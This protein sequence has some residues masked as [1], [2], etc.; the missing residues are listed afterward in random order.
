MKDSK[1]DNRFHYKFKWIKYRTIQ[2]FI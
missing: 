1:S 2:T